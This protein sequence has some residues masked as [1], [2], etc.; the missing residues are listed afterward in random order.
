MVFQL[1]SDQVGEVSK[2]FRRIKDLPLSA[3]E[4]YCRDIIRTFFITPTASSVWP[5]NSS[6][7][8]SISTLEESSASSLPPSPRAFDWPVRRQPGFLDFA[9][10]ASSN[11]L[12]FSTPFRARVANI[13][14]VFKVVLHPAR[15]RLWIWASCASLA[16]PTRSLAKANFSSAAARGS[17][18]APVYCCW[19]S[20]LLAKL[21][22]AMAW[23]NV[24]G[25]GFADG[26]AVR[27]A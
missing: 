19:R 10:A 18:P 3:W 14:L 5:T 8:C 2:W 1:C 20:W 6:S 16:S 21:A 24:F 12:E 9:L 11:S 23:L 25:C 27:A 4:G 7:A 26:G 22:R 17:S 15:N 13:R